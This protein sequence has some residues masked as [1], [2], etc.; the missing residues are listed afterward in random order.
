MTD[1]TS[2]NSPDTPLSDGNVGTDG[3][4]NELLQTT[5]TSD[6][7]EAE[8]RLKTVETIVA[9]DARQWDKDEHDWRS[10]SQ[11]I[12]LF[13]TAEGGAGGKGGKGGDGSVAIGSIDSGNGGDG[14]DGGHGGDAIATAGV[15]SIQTGGGRDKISV[16]ATAAGGDG[17]DGGAGGR[18]GFAVKS[19]NSG[20]GGDGGDAGDGG[21]ALSF[22][23]DLSI[24]AGGG[25]DRINLVSTALGGSAG[26]GGSGGHKGHFKGSIDSGNGGDGGD[27]GHG[28][29]AGSFIVD[30]SVNAG[31]GNDD[32]RLA[33]TA[34]A[35]SSGKSGSYGKG[36]SS[37]YGAHSG[38]GGSAGE[39]GS[40]SAGI[41]H[42]SVDAG[43]G[44]DELRINLTAY[45][46]K[47][48]KGLSAN[49]V[50]SIE[51][52][53][54]TFL[55]NDGDDTFIL[56]S[57]INKTNSIFDVSGNTFDGGT[58]HDKFDLKGWAKAISLDFANELLDLGS[59][60]SNTLKNFESI[61]GTSYADQFKFAPHAS[62]LKVTG[63]SGSD[64]YLVTIHDQVNDIISDFSGSSKGGDRLVI[65]DA[66]FSNLLGGAPIELVSVNDV[67][68]ASSASSHGYFIYDKSG[69][70][71]G[72]LYFDATG[73]ASSDAV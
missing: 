10:Y 28:G 7:E 43:Q 8:R 51:L 17:G 23:K 25:N 63:G 67:A 73:G 61:V 50:A 3:V 47:N 2:L 19:I 64:S 20:N 1:S 44:N 55:G 33:V 39:G 56:A 58:G 13:A 66:V 22:I 18:G 45:V 41:V 35:A 5:R 26:N 69:A 62:G 14:G 68:A 60:A 15:A 40:A 34:D 53:D 49:T 24:D 36:G 72:S 31:N 30:S 42:V 57:K 12:V 21:A 4:Q 37:A 46:G 32:I 71:A 59:G 6:S 9:S 52:T 54:N 27:A 48:G 11:K 70:A 65:D 16:F 29:N 38:S